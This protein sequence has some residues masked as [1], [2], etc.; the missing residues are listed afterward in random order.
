MC[1]LWRAAAQPSDNATLAGA[2][3]TAETGTKESALRFLFCM[4]F[5]NVTI[6]CGRQSG[7]LVRRASLA[8][9]PLERSFYPRNITPFRGNMWP[10][11]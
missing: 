9:L 3:F 2:T 4:S 11:T 7:E 10:V 8:A 1:S 6:S 5:S